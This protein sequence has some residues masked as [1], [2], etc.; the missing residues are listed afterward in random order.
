[1]I[2]RS[3][4]LFLMAICLVWCVNLSSQGFACNDQINVTVNTNCA[5]DLTVDALIEGDTDVDEDIEDG[6]YTYEIYTSQGVIVTGGINGP[7]TGGDYMADYVNTIVFFRVIYG[8]VVKC[9]GIISLEDKNDPVIDCEICPVVNGTSAADYAPECIFS[10]YEQPILQLQYDAGLRDDIIQEDYEDF[11][12][13]AMTDNCNNWDLNTVSY[14]D[15]W[16]TLGACEGSVLTRTWSV[17]WTKANGT[18]GTVSCTREYFFQPFELE[19]AREYDNDLAGNTIVEPILDSII[20]PIS[21]I[22]I[23]CGSDVSPSAVAAFFDN[24]LTEDRDSDDNNIDPDELDIDLVVENNEGIPYAYPHF[25]QDGVGSG[26]P[27]PQ[28]LNTDICNLI[29]TYTD[30][31]V[32]ACGIGC[33]GNTKILRNWIILDWCESVFIEY[34]QLIKA[35]DTEAPVITVSA[36]QVSVDPWNCEANITLPSPE[37]LTDNC[38]P[39]PT[40]RIGNSGGFNVVG[41]ITDGF[42]LVGASVG[43][44]QVEYITEDCCGNV[45]R[46]YISVTVVDNTPPVAVSK[47]F[48]VTSLTNLRIQLMN[49]K[50]LQRYMLL[51][52]T[53][54][55]MMD[56]QV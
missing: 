21:D 10:C 35:V 25:Y 39:N 44:H 30:T 12:D 6:L 27:H 38:D 32:D 34:G 49:F 18:I 9:G 52:S 17:G 43:T 29:T 47:E 16:N 40:Y 23:P 37:H 20:F 19:T 50:D 51:T 55:V 7:T 42:T 54:E 28:A 53:M 33:G 4:T 56:V 46:Q 14:Y 8:S 36:I 2:K 15:L 31:N 41:S 45:G 1:M 11:A 13:D 5:I 26:G 48:I 22:Q 24:T 3:Y